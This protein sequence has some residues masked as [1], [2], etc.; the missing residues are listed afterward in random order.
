MWDRTLT[1]DDVEQKD[2]IVWCQTEHD[3]ISFLNE[4]HTLGW[5]WCGGRQLNDARTEWHDDYPIVYHLNSQHRYVQWGMKT[6]TE[7][8]EFSSRFRIFNGLLISCQP[9]EVGDLL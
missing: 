8:R 1:I 2:P 7:E 9:V 4:L 6:T 5:E 3:A